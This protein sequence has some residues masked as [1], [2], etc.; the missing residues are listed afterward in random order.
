MAALGAWVE[1]NQNA[2]PGCH[3]VGTTPARM[4]LASPL[5]GV[6]SN[7][8]TPPRPGWTTRTTAMT[9]VAGAVTVLPALRRRADRPL[10]EVEDMSGRVY[11]S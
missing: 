3:I 7:P 11:A 5:S 9:S 8:S 6:Y 4:H 10:V 2:Y 1:H